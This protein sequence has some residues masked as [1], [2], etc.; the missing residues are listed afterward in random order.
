MWGGLIMLG[1]FP[2][3]FDSILVWIF[4]HRTVN[5][6][7]VSYDWCISTIY[8]YTGSVQNLENFKQGKKMLQRKQLQ[9][10][11]RLIRKLPILPTRLQKNRSSIRTMNRLLKNRKK[12]IP[13]VIDY[14]AWK[15]K[16]ICCPNLIIT[17]KGENLLL[18][19][20]AIPPSCMFWW[21]YGWNVQFF[22]N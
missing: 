5:L 2:R 17:L 15:K 22:T 4:F 21:A 16:D 13:R 12:S 14:F 3:W 10:V 1:T 18:Q 6:T 19:N 8:V 20:I 9:K 7:H 11:V